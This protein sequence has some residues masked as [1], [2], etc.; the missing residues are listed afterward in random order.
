ML[1]KLCPSA[2]LSPLKL[3]DRLEKKISDVNSFSYSI[4]NIKE[5]NI[6][7]IDKNQESKKKY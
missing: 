3:E 2:L 4:K 1:T 7:F 6:Y 5:M